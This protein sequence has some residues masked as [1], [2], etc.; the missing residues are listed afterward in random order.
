[1]FN[2]T[3]KKFSVTIFLAEIG[4]YREIQRVYLAMNG[5]PHNYGNCYTHIM[6]LNNVLKK[7]TTL[8]S[9]CLLTIKLN[10]LHDL[11]I[12]FQCAEIGVPREIQRPV[13]SH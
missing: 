12:M 1:V 6:S 9:N 10:Y 13:A 4:V 8:L 2:T 3:F 5:V 7:E 11:K